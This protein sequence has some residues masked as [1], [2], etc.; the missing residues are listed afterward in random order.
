MA[1]VGWVGMMELLQAVPQVVQWLVHLVS[2]VWLCTA[3]GTRRQVLEV[4]LA[5]AHAWFPSEMSLQ[6]LLQ[7]RNVQSERESPREQGANPRG[8]G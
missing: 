4:P 3:L 7:L 5:P 2:C 8:Q 6:H 1:T